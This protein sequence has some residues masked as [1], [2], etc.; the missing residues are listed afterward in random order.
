MKKRDRRERGVIRQILGRSEVMGGISGY[1][2][3]CSLDVLTR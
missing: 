2:Q 3:V 1:T